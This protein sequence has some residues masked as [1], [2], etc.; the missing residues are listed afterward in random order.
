VKYADYKRFGTTTTIIYNG[1]DITNKNQ[2]QQPGTQS[3]GTPLPNGRVD[4]QGS[5]Q[6]SPAP[7]Q[8]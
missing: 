4:D 2:P 7:K 5:R 8:K 1:Q 6:P 3:Q